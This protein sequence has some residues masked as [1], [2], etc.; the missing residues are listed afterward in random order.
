EDTLTQL[1]QQYT[2]DSPDEDV[3]KDIQPLVDEHFCYD[4]V[5]DI[6]DSLGKDKSDSAQKVKETLLTKSPVSLK[7]TLKQLVDVQGRSCADSLARDLAI[8]GHFIEH[9]DFLE[10]V[11]SVL[12]D[13]DHAPNYRFKTLE[14]VSKNQLQKFIA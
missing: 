8:G 5:E 6:V 3:L 11:P 10:G 7:V 12:I 13:K 9:P 14:D 2:S 1:I 4:T